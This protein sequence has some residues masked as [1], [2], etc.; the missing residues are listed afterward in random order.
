MKMKWQAR[1]YHY[2]EI[3]GVCFIASQFWA[4]ALGQLRLFPAIRD[5]ATGD[6]TEIKLE[7]G[8]GEEQV[9]DAVKIHEQ[10]NRIQDPGGGR[11]AL[12]E[13]YGRNMF[14]AGE[15]N[16]VASLN[17]D[18]LEVWEFLS[19]DEW[20][21]EGSLYKRVEDEGAA[22]KTYR[23]PPE[24]AQLEKGQALSYRVWRPHPRFSKRADSPCRGILDDLEEITLLTAT[25]HAYGISRV[26]G[27]GM[28]LMP[29]E[30]SEAPPQPVGDEDPVVDPLMEEII[31][32]TTTPIANPSSPTAVT[33]M[34]LR[35]KA[36]YLKE[37][38]M[39]K[40]VDPAT[41]FPA[42]GRREEAI[43]RVGV[44]LDMPPQKLTG[45]AGENHWN[46]WLADEEAWDHI[47]PE[48]DR[49]CSDFAA[50]VLRPLCKAAGVK[51]WENVALGY[52]N[53]RVVQKPDRSGIALELY[54]AELIGG[55]AARE[56][57]G[58]KETDKPDEDELAEMRA[59]KAAAAGD[60]P[61]PE[62]PVDGTADRGAPEMVE[63]DDE[64]APTVAAAALSL[65][66]RVAAASD[67]AVDRC[68]ELAGSRIWRQASNACRDC[69]AE[70]KDEPRDQ[71]AALLGREKL[72]ELG[73][74]EASEL[75]AGGADQFIRTIARWGLTPDEAAA[76]ARRVEDHAAATLF[77]LSPSPLVALRGV[78]LEEAA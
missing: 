35:G 8:E 67:V 73:I 45:T 1:A 46:A 55:R 41:A 9:P 3:N 39:L 21:V 62:P 23:K 28:L 11:Q 10:W 42:E 60:A 32:A 74:P 53:S 25:V 65:G 63:P 17:D 52:D 40:F 43:A 72:A 24:G 71:L 49:M 50:V 34:I 58:F 15:G 70:V 54:D 48:A 68:R 66:S 51:D 75:V 56:A 57:T 18:E 61:D 12:Q 64:P 6:L 76:A 69:V 37:V 20:Q 2:Y 27:P 31:E 7:P 44:K 26:S 30:V 19:I 29:E 59:A 13:S 77:D 16:L 78:D 5:P 38:R 4:R 36:E 47:A 14:L 22:A 33:P